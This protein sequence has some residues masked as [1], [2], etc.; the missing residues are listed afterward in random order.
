MSPYDSN[1]LIDYRRGGP[2]H[3]YG[4]GTIF[5]NTDESAG[6]ETARTEPGILFHFKRL[7]FQA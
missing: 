7:I 3:F 1:L 6:G 5:F 2:S 4:D